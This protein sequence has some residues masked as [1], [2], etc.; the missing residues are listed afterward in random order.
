MAIYKTSIYYIMANLNDEIE[1]VFSEE[2]LQGKLLFFFKKHRRYIYAFLGVVILVLLVVACGTIFS[3]K[4]SLNIKR[5]YLALTTTNSKLAFVKKYRAHELCGLVL[6][7]LGDDAF[8]DKDFKTALLYY[9]L[10]IKA[11]KHNELSVRAEIS[12]AN[13]KYKLG[14]G[15]SYEAILDKILHNSKYNIC[16]RAKAL[17]GLLS[18]FKSQGNDMAIAELMHFADGIN[19]SEN[20]W[21][22]LS[23]ISK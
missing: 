6:L 15:K 7:N 2:S 3:E 20:W 4:R 1:K 13:S 11:L 19:F 8:E 18:H 23:S 22:L 16:F 21:Q 12:V 17:Y 10:A 14:D 9:E 5:E